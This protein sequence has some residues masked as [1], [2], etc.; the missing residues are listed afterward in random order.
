MA[1]SATTLP[2]V[3]FHSAPLIATTRIGI[4]D[5]NYT[6]GTRETIIGYTKL[7]ATRTVTFSN[8]AP[9]G[10][11]LII[12]DESG[13]CSTTNQIVINATIDGTTNLALSSAY[14]WAELYFNGTTW[15]R[16]A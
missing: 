13:S 1:T 8:S 14:A 7:S 15:S 4:D 11:R 16:V 3:S 5:S 6:I 9:V 10:R 12:K 2:F